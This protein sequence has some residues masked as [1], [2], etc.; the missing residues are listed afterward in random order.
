[1]ADSNPQIVEHVVQL[2]RDL[3]T[4]GPKHLVVGRYARDHADHE[5]LAGELAKLEAI[6]D[7][8]QTECVDKPLAARAEREAKTA[9]RRGEARRRAEEEAKRKAA[10][11]KAS[12]TLA[13]IE[14][15]AVTNPEGARRVLEAVTKGAGR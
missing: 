6:A 15:L 1:M 7:V 13:A 4:D 11:R 10:S 14:N 3:A 5:R 8:I 12:E 9:A 2:L